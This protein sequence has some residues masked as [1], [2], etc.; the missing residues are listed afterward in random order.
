MDIIS[1]NKKNLLLL[2]L[3][4]L[5]LFPYYTF[6]Q[7][8]AIEHYKSL[9]NSNIDYS[10][11][12]IEIESLITSLA[13]QIN[14][15]EL[16]NL[17]SLYS[18][19]CNRQKDYKKAIINAKKALEIQ[20]SHIDTFPSQVNNTYSNLS[21]FY[22]KSGKE[23]LS[24]STLKK[25]ITLD[26]KDKFT[27]AAYVNGLK[28]I[29][30]K[31]GDYYQALEYISEAE[32][33]IQIKKDTI[34]DKEFY[35]IPIAYSGVYL[36]IGGDENYTKALQ[37]LKEAD[38]LNKKMITT[39]IGIK[40]QIIIHNRFGQ[41]YTK[42]KKHHK[43]IFHLEKALTIGLRHTKSKYDIAKI[44]NNLG[45]NYFKSSQHKI[46]FEN[47]QKALSYFPEYTA[48]Y[49]NLGDYYLYYQDYKNAL[50][51]YQ[52][53]IDY[54]IN[55]FKNHNYKQLPNRQLL[56]SSSYKTELLNDLK[57]KAK[58]WLSYYTKSG[59]QSH[60]SKAL[61]TIELADYMVDLIRSES[62]VSQS[63]F[64]WREKG[65]DLYI[66]ATSIA[67]QL[68]QPE[69]AFYFMEKSKSLTLLE[70]LTHEEA[71]KRA[72]LP[73]SLISL[74][75]E[76]KKNIFQIRKQTSKN[77]SITESDK[78][79]MIAKQKKAYHAFINSLEKEYP[80][81]YKYKRNITIAKHSE[82]L[83]KAAQ[84]NTS[85]IQYILS[86]QE[87]YGLL[88]TPKESFF[89]KI[90]QPQLLQN[91]ILD[92]GSL[93]NKSWE[94]EE[95]QNRFHKLSTSISNQLFAFTESNTHIN[96]EKI[97]IIPDGILQSF[98]F[99]I[100]QSPNTKSTEFSYLINDFDISY[101]YSMSLD[102]QIEKKDNQASKHIMGIAPVH[103]KYL[104]LP[105]LYL[106]SSKFKK[107]QE[108]I[109]VDT[110]LYDDATKSNFI[111][112]SENYQ[113]LHVS[114][115]ANSMNAQTPWIAFSDSK[116]TLNELYFI[117]NQADLVIL[118]ACKTGIGEILPGEGVS[119]L[120]KGF[121][122]S[123]SKSVLSSLWNTNEKS[124]NEIV[125]NFYNYL[126]AGNDK[127]TA[128]RKAKLDFIKTHQ[129]SEKSPYYWATLIITGDLQPINFPNLPINYFPIA[130]LIGLLFFSFFIYKKLN[131]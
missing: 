36:N 43:A 5:L 99:E 101:L 63:R 31:K 89:Y 56:A 100:L 87:A 90:D 32:R 4:S 68:K 113:I 77:S 22:M 84:T 9:E 96:S 57:D 107:I 78:K 72:K 116:L 125:L 73:D 119:S 91:Q 28:N 52:K 44:Y 115:H 58:A 71:K 121:F 92:I 124:S 39:K 16:S 74:E 26:H 114:S 48:V 55:I 37:H 40:N 98:P 20:I 126:K 66:L 65:L 41:V 29:A 3:F 30:I 130:F 24:F 45:V 83:K 81:Y 33:I 46:A 13:D 120:T 62:T 25:L 10:D 131:T 128:L 127:S 11:K 1:L 102:K 54:T 109:G 17:Y 7:Q 47:Y 15:I 12:T 104:G 19:F 69:K 76:L 38:S 70:N 129:G 59:D 103:F 79:H 53:A 27:I 123:G 18:K 82:C 8:S 97:V 50:L 95:D 6:A 61:A 111:N 34:L 64:F 118:D 108:E 80:N 51:H 85:Y 106:S 117:P 14:S 122:Y 105:S 93:L 21:V 42:L 75:Y 49:D 94:T 110:F 2:Y 35:R 60:L 67:Y 86:D 23:K 112:N 88:T